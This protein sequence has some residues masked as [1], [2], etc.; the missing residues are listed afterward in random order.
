MVDRLIACVP[1]G[2]LLHARRQRHR[3]GG[4]AR[5][6]REAERELPQPHLALRARRRGDPAHARAERRAL[7]R[8]SPVDDRL[9]FT[10]DRDLQGQDGAC[11]SSIRRKARPLGDIPGTI[12]DYRWTPDG[13]ALIAL[14][15]DRGLDGGATN[16]AVRLWWGEPE[17]P[18]VTN[19]TTAPAAVQGRR[20]RWRDR[21][22]S[23]PL[24]SPSGSST[25]SG[26]R[27]RRASS[28]PMRASAAGI[29]RELGA[30]RFRERGRRSSTRP[31]AAP[32]PCR[33]AFGQARRFRRRLVERSRPGGGRDP[34]R[35]S[36]D[37]QGH[38]VAAA[39]LSNVTT[40]AWRD[41]DTPVVRGLVE[42]R[43]DLRRHPHRRQRR[44]ARYEDA[45]V[46]TSS[47]AARLTPAPDKQGFAAVRET[48]GAAAG[49]R[50]Q[51]QRRQ[52]H[53]K[54][55][56]RAEPRCRARTFPPIPKC[57]DRVAG[58][59]R[60]RARRPAAPAAGRQ[61]AHCR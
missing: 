4:A 30:A 22:E 46:G 60:A 36:R 57:A 53:W 34:H 32:G 17:D 20:S 10:S 52:S 31:M 35:R 54:P 9:A 50:L 15:A 42:D 38:D 47:F 12:E 41:G 43:L 16:G 2:S 8:Y 21:R 25:S 6:R 18:E 48:A 24:T 14:A 19:P 26:R 13:T 49:D 11:S 44:L 29:M 56:T 40:L 45:I 58:Q 28:P 55:I 37:G 59:R 39:E 33:L 7:P 61:P 23:A 51:D 5:R 1:F 27:R 3:R